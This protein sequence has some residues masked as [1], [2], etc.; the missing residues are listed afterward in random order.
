M[1]REMVL[2]P[3]SQ[4][5]PE[6]TRDITIRLSDEEQGVII[7]V[8]NDESLRGVTGSAGG[9]TIRGVTDGE[10]TLNIT[11]PNNPNGNEDRQITVS[12]SNTI[13]ILDYAPQE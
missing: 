9:C 5:N 10:H 6:I 4:E 12:E 1:M 11:N 7:L 8:D 3:N 13:F 2:L